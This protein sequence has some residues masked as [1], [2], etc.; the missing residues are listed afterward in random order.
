MA[1]SI[2]GTLVLGVVALATWAGSFDG[3]LRALAEAPVAS[4][5][6]GASVTS[7]TTDR[8]RLQTPVM[9]ALAVPRSPGMIPLRGGEKLR[10]A[11]Q[12]GFTQD[13]RCYLVLAAKSNAKWIRI[14]FSDYAAFH[15]QKCRPF[16]GVIIATLRDR[17]FQRVASDSLRNPCRAFELDMYRVGAPRSVVRDMLTAKGCAR[18]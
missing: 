12:V 2:R 7:K 18:P 4:N 1:R 9:G 5:S 11:R 10:A 6:G 16:D 13:E 14:L 8:A 17:R 15:F 3:T